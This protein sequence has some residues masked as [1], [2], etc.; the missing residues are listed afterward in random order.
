[1]S[2]LGN[3]TFPEANIHVP[4]REYLERTIASVF[5]NQPDMSGDSRKRLLPWQ[6]RSVEDCAE[7]L[8]QVLPAIIEATGKEP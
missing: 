8:L 6:R 1:M 4:L 2:D 5:R 7:S 3:K